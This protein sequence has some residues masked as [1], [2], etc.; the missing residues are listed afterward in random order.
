MCE[1]SNESGQNEMRWL[2]LS[3]L[4]CVFGSNAAMITLQST[5]SRGYE[6]RGHNRW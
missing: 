4:L 5:V 1:S 6:C 2:S 3:L